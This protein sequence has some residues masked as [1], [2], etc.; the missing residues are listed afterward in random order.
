MDHNHNYYE[1]VKKIM[2]IKRYW[3]ISAI[4]IHIYKYVVKLLILLTVDNKFIANVINKLV[5]RKGLLRKESLDN[6]GTINDSN[7]NTKQ[8][9][10][11][12]YWNRN[13]LWLNGA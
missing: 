3:N 12:L 2:T 4:R 5:L 9:N 10:E 13:I 8:W 6:N 7:G 11:S 1:K